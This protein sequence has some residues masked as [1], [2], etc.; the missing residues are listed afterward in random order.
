M[1]VCRPNLAEFPRYMTYYGSPSRPPGGYFR[2]KTNNKRNLYFYSII[3]THKQVH[4][5]NDSVAAN[6]NKASP[7]KNNPCVLP[8]FDPQI[9]TLLGTSAKL[10][11]VFHHV[12]YCGSPPRRPETQSALFNVVYTI[13][14]HL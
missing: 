13:V 5:I 7:Q 6:T 2:R 3:N 4:N 8:W 14:R 1:N 12:T 10:A 11:K 9:L